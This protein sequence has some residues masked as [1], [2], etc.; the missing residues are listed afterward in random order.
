VFGR[1]INRLEFDPWQHEGLEK[2]PG[3]G[4]RLVIT[5]DMARRAVARNGG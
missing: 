2:L 3:G 4:H 5:R 1:I